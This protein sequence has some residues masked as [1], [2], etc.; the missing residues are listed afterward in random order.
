MP[1]SLCVENQIVN[2]L[3]RD[4]REGGRAHTRDIIVPTTREPNVE[5]SDGSGGMVCVVKGMRWFL[6]AQTR[7]VNYHPRQ[8][9]CAYISSLNTDRVSSWKIKEALPGFLAPAKLGCA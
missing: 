4:Q 6:K 5:L 9:H 1:Y 3:V 7:R 2:F 8:R